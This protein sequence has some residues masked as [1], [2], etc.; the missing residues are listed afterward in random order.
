MS[1]TPGMEHTGIDST[2][3]VP[4]T[5]P[6]TRFSILKFQLDTLCTRMTKSV[7]QSLSAKLGA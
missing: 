5:H 3:I 1:F 7:D 4:N 2:S 6:K